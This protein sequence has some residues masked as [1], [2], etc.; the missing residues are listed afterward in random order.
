MY[1]NSLLIFA[2]ERVSGTGQWIYLV[3]TGGPWGRTQN[4]MSRRKTGEASTVRA[5]VGAAVRP[6]AKRG[7]LF[8]SWVWPSLPTQV[9]SRQLS[10]NCGNSQ[11]FGGMDTRA[12]PTGEPE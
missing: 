6:C 2:Y 10:C 8:I 3:V 7:T 9:V 5:K 11:V 1:G 12:G 4:W